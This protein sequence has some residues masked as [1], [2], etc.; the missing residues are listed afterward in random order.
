MST[1]Y[2]I[3]F[4]CQ[5]SSTNTNITRWV[6]WWH[7][8]DI[9]IFT[10]KNA[11]ANEKIRTIVYVYRCVYFYLNERLISSRLSTTNTTKHKQSFGKTATVRLRKI[12]MCENVNILLRLLDR[13]QRI[14]MFG[15]AQD[16]RYEVIMALCSIKTKI[17]E[18]LHE[19]KNNQSII[20]QGIFD[21][22]L[23][24]SD[25]SDWGIWT[26]LIINIF[27]IM[28]K[29]TMNELKNSQR[30]RCINIMH[31]RKMKPV[32]QKEIFFF[33]L[34]HWSFYFLLNRCPLVTNF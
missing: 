22:L 1:E 6:C 8:P 15:F 34:F 25:L 23:W 20:R 27:I 5:K 2:E 33:N 11:N 28:T 3:I 9:Y 24:T 12:I 16:A 30:T 26:E 7:R 10:K 19:R 29:R 31:L 4:L 14:S 13:E 21:S 18:L 17:N 32:T